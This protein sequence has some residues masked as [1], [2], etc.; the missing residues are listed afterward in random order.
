VPRTMLAML[1]ET[2]TSLQAD[3]FDEIE[4]LVDE[5]RSQ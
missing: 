2:S 4:R 1:V 3:V 5:M